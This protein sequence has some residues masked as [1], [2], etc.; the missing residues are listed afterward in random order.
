MKLKRF[1]FVRL[2]SIPRAKFTSLYKTHGKEATIVVAAWNSKNPAR[3]DYVAP[4]EDAL[5]FITTIILP[6]LP[7]DGGSITL[8]EGSF[9]GSTDDKPL[10]ISS[11]SNI[12]IQGQ[13]KGTEL[14]LG[15]GISSNLIVIENSSAIVIDSLYLNGQSSSEPEWG[16]DLKQ[17][18]I[19]FNT[20]LDSKIQNVW[21]SDCN[22]S[23]ISLYNSDKNEVSGANCLVNGEC[24]ILLQYSNNNAIIGNTS[25]ENVGLGIGLFDSSVSNSISGNTCQDNEDEGIKLVGDSDDNAVSGNT[26]YNNTSRGIALSSCSKCTITGNSCANNGSSGI[27]VRHGSKKIVIS[28]NTCSGNTE[29]GIEVYSECEECILIGNGVRESG[30]HGVL[31]DTKCNHTSVLNNGITDNGKAAGVGIVAYDG[32][33]VSNDS[34][35][36]NLQ[37]NTIRKAGATQTHRYGIN[38]ADNDCDENLVTNNDLKDA[39]VTADFNDNGTGTVTVAG[40]RT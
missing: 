31:I 10:M 13:G 30:Q 25:N 11:K 12:K 29:R 27:L 1:G 21:V 14:H 23:G 40:N 4:K 24:G 32:I 7:L 9:E 34:N 33:K 37:G 8:L 19:L 20:V 36:N 22:L 16:V 35:L 18:G 38:I 3:A 15:T 6:K 39:G 28:S 2:P 5:D 26:C 17:H